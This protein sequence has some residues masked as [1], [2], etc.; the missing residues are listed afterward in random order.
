MNTRD[1]AIVLEKNIKIDLESIEV[2]VFDLDGTLYEDVGHFTYYAERLKEKLPENIQYKFQR[3]YKKALNNIHALKIGRVYDVENDLILVYKDRVTEAY[4]WDGQQLNES[5]IAEFYPAP[6]SFDMER[7]I[8]IGDSW[9]IPAAIALHYGL[10]SKESY[11]AFLETRDYMKG[12]EYDI[13]PVKGLK[14]V[15]KY[16]SNKVRLVLLT[17]SPKPDSEAI[18]EKLSLNHIFAEKVFNAQKPAKAKEQFQ[19]ISNNFRINYEAILSVG[20]NYLNEI[21]P[22]K[23]LGCQSLFI[24]HYSL[25]LEREEGLSVHNCKQ[26]VQFLK[27]L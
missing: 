15:L 3:D 18:L 16:L 14:E 21:L 25:G 12:P 20:D 13:S 2:I 26:L 27:K 5:K 6:L 7:M 19:N 23:K 9:W 4:H 8:S 17:N 11:Q 24:D 10:N 22:A 1:E